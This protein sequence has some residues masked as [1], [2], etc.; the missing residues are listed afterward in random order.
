[1]HGVKTFA[2][3][4]K[5]LPVHAVSDFD[6]AAAESLDKHRHHLWGLMMDRALRHPRESQVGVYL[7]WGQRNSEGLKTGY[8]CM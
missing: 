6:A 2:K 3:D 4:V 8:A 1:M 7:S 5:F